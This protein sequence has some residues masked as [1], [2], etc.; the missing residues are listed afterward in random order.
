MTH[1]IFHGTFPLLATHV[2]SWSLS[3]TLKRMNG[4][5]LLIKLA[6]SGTAYFHQT[7][8]QNNIMEKRPPICWMTQQSSV[9]KS[10][11]RFHG[12]HVN[13]TQTLS[14]YHCYKF[15]LKAFWFV[16]MNIQHR[17]KNKNSPPA[18]KTAHLVEPTT[19]LTSKTPKPRIRVLLCSHT[20][21][22]CAWNYLFF[23]T[24]CAKTKQK[25]FK[26]KKE[27][28]SK[29]LICLVRKKNSLE[30]LLIWQKQFRHGRHLA[31][32]PKTGILKTSK[33]SLALY[34]KLIKH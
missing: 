18:V 2:N 27:E 31:R 4:S 6:K 29:H 30:L 21:F 8:F 11:I 24:S 14:S 20:V 15:I 3:E 9:V 5:S 10:R 16:Y 25:D 28:H 1:Y 34:K 23:A 17:A 19:F 7:Q 32:G 22:C 12:C 13:T 33:D 26:K